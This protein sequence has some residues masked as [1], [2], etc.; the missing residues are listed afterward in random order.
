MQAQSGACVPS[1]E[2]IGTMLMQDHPCSPDSRQSRGGFSQDA[3]GHYWAIMFQ[4]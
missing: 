2:A 1:P 3:S 4:S